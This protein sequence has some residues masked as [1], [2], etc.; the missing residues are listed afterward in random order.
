MIPMMIRA[1]IRTAT[2][3]A[4]PMMIRTA[5]ATR[6]ATNSLRSMLSQPD[7]MDRWR[8]HGAYVRC[9]AAT[10][11]DFVAAGLLTEKE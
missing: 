5:T 6:I 9:V 1:T 7:G 3:T 4:I 8:N 2:R 11:E 10:T